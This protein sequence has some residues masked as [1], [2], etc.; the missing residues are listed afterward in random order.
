MM[1][2]CRCLVCAG[3]LTINSLAELH[4]TPTP[5]YC[6]RLDS[7]CTATPGERQPYLPHAPEAPGVPTGPILSMSMGQ[8]TTV[9]VSS[10]YVAIKFADRSRGPRGA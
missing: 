7:P 2:R 8:E 1:M 9:T 6:G 5:W 3:L 4:A 10:D